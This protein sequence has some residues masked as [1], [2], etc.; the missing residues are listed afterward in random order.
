MKKTVL[1]VFFIL[2]AT[3]V[4]SQTFRLDVKDKPLNKVLPMLGVEISFDDRALSAWNVS[5][6]ASFRDAEEALRRLLEDK[7]FHIEKIGSVYVVVP[8]DANVRED[9]AT[10]AYPHP[11]KERSVLTGT[12]VDRSTREPLEYA[13]VS[14]LG[15]DSRPFTAGVTNGRGRFRINA[16]RTPG[17][18][19]ISYLGY[20]TLLT[21]AA[22]NGD[23]ELGVFPLETAVIPL[24]ETVVTAGRVREGI[25]RTSY[26]VT[27]RMREGVSSALELS[28]RIPGVHFD[29]L[30]ETVRVNHHSNILLLV[31]GIQYPPAYLKHLSPHRIHAVELIHAPAGRF[32]SDDYGAIVNFT[33][34]EDYAGYDVHASGVA[35]LNLSGAD[36][37]DRTAETRPSA[38]V[39]YSA[40]RMNFF[41]T[42]AYDREDRRMYS[43]K[44]LTYGEY[45]LASLPA[46]RPNSLYG[47]ARNTLTGGVNYRVAP[48]HTVSVQGD[49]TSGTASTR[50]EY[51]MRRT[52]PTQDYNRTLKNTTEILTKDNVSTAM[53]SY[54]GQFAGRLRL[55]GDFS[56]NYYYNVIENEYR[57]NEAANYRNENA[58]DE[59][60]NQT[61]FNAEGKYS[62]SASLSAEA[63]YS[64]IRRSYASG[65]SAG[66]GFL[67]YREDRNRA[68]AYVSFY[69]SEKTGFRT[70][71]ALEHINTRNRGET[72]NRYLRV[73]PCFQL[74]YRPGKAAN[75]MAGYT[76]G[77]SYPA[78]YQLSPMSLVIDTFLMQIGNPALKPAVRH[79][80]FAELSLR[81]GLRIMPQV[82]F[83][84]DAI[85]EVYERK[86][87]RL[88][89]TFDNVHTREYSLQAS[90]DRT[91]G[92]YFGTKNAVMLYYGE[93]R[94]DGVRNSIH[95]WLYFSELN[96]Y[97]PEKSAGMQLGYYRNMRK[98]ILWQGYQ[99]SERDYW[100]VSAQKE[101][102]RNRVSVSLSWIPPLAPGVR[103]G[104]TKEM[105]TPL[106]GEKTTLNL[107][108]Y[109]QMLILKV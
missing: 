77:Q 98:N 66:R 67:D 85:S 70:G 33:L 86:E 73:L 19:K 97:H 35:S 99:M 68:F 74:D 109:R 55:Y 40:G 11:A 101:L 87:Y 58:Y 52:D 34:T 80:A 15:A 96:F 65:S 29:R 107:Y 25:G 60:K 1:A 82:S 79:H 51:V 6:S 91:F 32:V 8:A 95:G 93:A 106:Y 36:G 48:E 28:D 100:R 49:H 27:P 61:V 41:G 16:S 89:R 26:A 45:K 90:F 108:A 94:H 14:L 18:I 102:W 57:Q 105:D 75:I 69:L 10:T 76:A 12:V 4:F 43:S 42:Y 23:S 56:Y 7:P 72:I 13:T 17:K 81:N 59:Y 38:G 54:Q 39:I 21:D 63:G 2:T 24:A 50:Q 64:G 47:H 5:V 44:L 88:Y 20:E 84:R 71:V 92:T 62:V 37:H 46:E 103:Y 22:G 104:R 78:L 31:D 3:H 83:T 9:T 53:L 30:S